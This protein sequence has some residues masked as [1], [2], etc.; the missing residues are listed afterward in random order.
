MTE[1]PQFSI[2]LRAPFWGAPPW[3][4]VIDLALLLPTHSW[5]LIGGLMVALHAEL[6]GHGPSRATTDVD[7]TLH[8]E[9]ESTRFSQVVSTLTEHGYVL[10]AH[11][12]HAYRFDRGAERIDVMCSDR[13]AAYRKPQYGG[14]PLFGVPGATRA[15]KNTINVEA[16]TGA[17]C[18]KLVLPT[19][20]GALILKGAALME[21]HRAPARH[22]EDGV[23]LLACV[24]N[25]DD[26]SAGLSQRSR[27]RLRHLCTTLE[28]SPRAWDSHSRDVQSLARESLTLLR[29]N[30]TG[31]RG[32]GH[33][34]HR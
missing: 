8:L 22:A 18:I 4:T 23:L 3:P 24:E 21:D 11:T 29:E 33:R 15:L 20:Q 10:D 7:A 9:T 31:G 19:L 25:V 16:S 6:A 32:P 1:R 14:R 27:R 26:I 34:R 30:L 5:T 2:D 17:V 13:Y 28:G 12:T